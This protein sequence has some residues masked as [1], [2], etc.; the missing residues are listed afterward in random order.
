MIPIKT[1]LYGT[2]AGLLNAVDPEVGKEISIR[3]VEELQ[4]ALTENQWTK[5]KLLV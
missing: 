1:P 4:L 2:L 5:A 3:A